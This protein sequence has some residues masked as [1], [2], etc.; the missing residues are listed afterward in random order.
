MNQIILLPEDFISHNRVLLKGRRFEHL[1]SVL[2]SQRGDRLKA[3][4]LNG[5]AGSAFLIERNQN[6]GILEVSLTEDPPP[7]IPLTLVVAMPRPKSFKKLIHYATAMGVKKI[8]V[9]RTWRVEKS[10]FSSPVLEEDFLREEMILALEQACDTILPEVFVRKLFRPFVEDELPL[11]SQ[12]TI[13]L[14]AHPY[15]NAHF[16]RCVNKPVTL[17]IGPE[18]GFISYEVELLES[19]GFTTV[20]LGERILRVENALPAI[21]GRL[22]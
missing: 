21:I 16:P 20:S 5:K 22:F 13:K 2:N 9:I 15:S 18:G 17:A 4:L 19:L 12:N 6:Y 14:T 7:P 1:V 3:G 11:I 8:Y 10:Y